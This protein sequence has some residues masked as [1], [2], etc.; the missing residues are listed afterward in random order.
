MSA[1]LTTAAELARMADELHQA[2]AEFQLETT[3]A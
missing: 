2:V 3:T 1:T